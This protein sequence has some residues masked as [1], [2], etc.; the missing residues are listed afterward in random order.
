MQTDTTRRA[1]LGTTG[2]A[3][4]LLIAPA[5]ASSS[6]NEVEAAF[7]EWKAIRAELNSAG[8]DD[9]TDDADHPIWA[10]LTRAETVIEGS[11]ERGA[12]VAEIRLW[13]S[14]TGD[15][16]YKS[17]NDALHREDV[18]WLIAHADQPEYST[19]MALR[20]IKALRGEAWA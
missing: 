7:A 8:H 6:G 17:E 3:G 18:E 5:T 16:I 1:V 14:M 11:Q 13:L 12:R 9:S 15:L 4:G 20:A 19:I 2:L 10:R